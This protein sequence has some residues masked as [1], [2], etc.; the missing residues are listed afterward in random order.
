MKIKI[1]GLFRPVDVTYVNEALPDYAGFVFAK[2]RRK[3]SL[4]LAEEMRSALDE[5]ITPVGVFVD[6]PIEEIVS[7]Y[8]EGIIDIAQL[9]GDESAEYIETL[10][11]HCKVKIIRAVSVET[12]HD[13]RRA[14]GFGADH[15]LLDN[16]PGGTGVKFD[17][18]LVKHVTKPFFLAG[19]INLS[20]ME[21]ALHLTPA[22]YAL[23]IS[24]GAEID[25]L[26]DRDTIIK[27][28][29]TVRNADA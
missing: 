20:N 17:W 15:L 16:G 13:I 1:C 3:V 26:K 2:S 5:K 22:P 27:L 9:H 19:G 14:N 29:E 24:S 28:V 7:I 6:S 23:D 4:D 8:E 18:S 12:E 11:E 21:D 25:G 10:R